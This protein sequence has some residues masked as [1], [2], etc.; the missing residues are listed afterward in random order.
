[1]IHKVSRKKRVSVRWLWIDK[2]DF[3]TI[4]SFPENYTSIKP[5]IIYRYADPTRF[6]A[7]GLD[8]QLHSE[9]KLSPSFY[10]TASLTYQL[11]N[12]FDRI[13]DF[14]DSPYLPHVRTDVAKYL[15]QRSDIYLN[16]FQ[17]DKLKKISN[18]HYLKFTG[19]I[20]EMMFGG[21]GIEYLWKP[22][23]KNT[24][25]GLNIYK[26]RQRDFK[27]VFG[28]QKYKV[29]T[30]HLNVLHFLPNS[31]VA[32]DLSIGQYLAGDVGY[33]FDLSRRFNSGFTMGA[34]FTR[35]NISKIEYGEGSFDKGIFFNIPV[36]GNFINYSWRPLTKDPG[37][38]LN[39]RYSLHDLLIK[40]RPHNP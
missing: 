20:F 19:G 11:Y 17:I 40:F 24:S 12:S 29:T 33:T 39:R 15:T 27:Q 9:I 34:Y 26:V 35:T 3:Q 6:F 32:I 5:E 16:N 13:R 30:G 8:V 36:Y 18:G 7:G 37:A 22:F 14:P 10:A 25:V 38:R 31:G 4:L 28:F 21:Y 1:M 23:Y 2:Y